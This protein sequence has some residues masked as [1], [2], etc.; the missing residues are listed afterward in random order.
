MYT[1]TVPVTV[2]VALANL[3]PGPVGSGPSRHHDGPMAL[4][5]GRGSTV[6]LAVARARG[7]WHRD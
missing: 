5:T 6:T 4:V 7:R 3:K 2:T 1:V